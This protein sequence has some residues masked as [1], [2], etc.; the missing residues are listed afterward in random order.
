M[1]R[2]GRVSVAE[3]TWKRTEDGAESRMGGQGR[4]KRGS[5]P[6]VSRVPR[7]AEGGV[8]TRNILH[9]DVRG[10]QPGDERL[11][12]VVLGYLVRHCLRARTRPLNLSRRCGCFVREE[13]LG[14]L[15][16]CS[17]GRLIRYRTLR[18]PCDIRIIRWEIRCRI[19]AEKLEA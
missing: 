11:L 13:V 12:E 18:G 10:P 2:Q 4:E 5:F 9:L 1:S 7:G 19:S 8:R 14:A 3:D 15:S 17:G 6:D 16:R